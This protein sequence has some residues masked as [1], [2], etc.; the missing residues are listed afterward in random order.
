MANKNYF[1]FIDIPDG[2][3][4]VARLYARDTEAHYVGLVFDENA[5]ATSTTPP[6]TTASSSTMGKVY[7][8]GPSS[9]TK[10][11]WV[12]VEDDSTTPSTYSWQQVGDTDVDFTSLIAS[13]QNIR[14]IVKNYVTSA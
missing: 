5:Q 6:S 14:N 1:E 3:G 7:L 9:G 10:Y 2:N 4:G 12:T 8:V 13:E 11:Q